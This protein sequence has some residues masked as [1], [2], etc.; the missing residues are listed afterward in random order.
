MKKTIVIIGLLSTAAFYSCERN[1]NLST[2]DFQVAEDEVLGLTLSE[3]SNEEDHSV[4]MEAP[5]LFMKGMGMEMG[6]P[7]H[8]AECAI[9]TESSE[10][11]PKDIT[12]DFGEECTDWKGNVKTGQ[13]LISITDSMIVEGAMRTATFV[14]FS[15]RGNIMEGTR[16]AVNQGKNGDGNWIIQKQ[17]EI[18]I[19]RE[20]GGTVSRTS[21]S[22]IEWIEGFGTP[23][24]SDD[25]FYISSSGSMILDDGTAYS[26][27]TTEPLLVD[28]SCRFILSGTVE[29]SNAEGSTVIDFGDGSCDNTAL[30]TKDGETKEIDLNTCRMRSKQ[31]RFKWGRS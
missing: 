12:I 11:F 8:L 2:A 23:E 31:K 28:R 22:T 17:S 25:I 29:I 4:V 30:V 5:G 14:D 19:T 15:I 16:T 1:N 3:A 26:R 21:T 13:I 24:K 10:S 18:T 7:H 6:H 20:D 9:V 27:V